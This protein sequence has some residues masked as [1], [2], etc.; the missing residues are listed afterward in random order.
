[1]SWQKKDGL[2]V[3]TPASMLN[4][5]VAYFNFSDIFGIIFN[6]DLDKKSG[7]YKN[8][9]KYKTQKYKTQKYKTQKYETQKYVNGR[10]RGLIVEC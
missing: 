1:M 3:Y 10:P 6:S 2:L 8:Y 4:E 7:N 9:G 5:N